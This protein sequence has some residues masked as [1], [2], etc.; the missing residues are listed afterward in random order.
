MLINAR[1]TKAAIKAYMVDRMATPDDDGIYPTIAGARVYRDRFGP[2][3]LDELPAIMVYASEETCEFIDVTEDRNHLKI[4][5][6]FQ[7][8]GDDADTQLD[9]LSDTVYDLFRNDEYLGGRED[10]L[11]EWCR[12][13]RGQ[14]YYDEKR[15]LNGIC[16]VMDYD[17]RYI[18]SSVPDPEVS[19][20]APFETVVATYQ[21][22]EDDPQPPIVVDEVTD[23]ISIPQV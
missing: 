9:F 4:Q 2:L 11:V 18:R 22:A 6:E 7:A 23:T 21:F 12:Y 20:M 10:G 3:Q 5:I 19:N 8:A 13:S 17:I 16:W 15:H 1:T 14:L